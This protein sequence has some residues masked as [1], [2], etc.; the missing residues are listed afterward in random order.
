[1]DFFFAFIL[2]DC[3]NSQKAVF[4]LLHVMYLQFFSWQTKIWH[5][6]RFTKSVANGHNNVPILRSTWLKVGGFLSL[7][8]IFILIMASVFLKSG[9]VLFWYG[10]LWKKTPTFLIF[11]QIRIQIIFQKIFALFF[12][13]FIY[14]IYIKSTLYIYKEYITLNNSMFKCRNGV[15]R[16]VITS[17]SLDRRGINI[18]EIQLS[19]AKN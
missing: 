5:E 3:Y 19:A 6:R 11:V 4:K 15:L 2:P 8:S 14:N 12:L 13:V 1:M 18:T 7:S 17:L 16:Y 10:S 9:T